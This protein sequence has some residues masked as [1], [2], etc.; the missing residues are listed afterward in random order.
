[1]PMSPENAN[2]SRKC[3]CLRFFGDIIILFR[4]HRIFGD[5]PDV[6][7]KHYHIKYDLY[8]LQTVSCCQKCIYYTRLEIIVSWAYPKH[9]KSCKTR[10]SRGQWSFKYTV[11]RIFYFAQRPVPA[12]MAMSVIAV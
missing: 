6:I 10:D 1:M 3:K 11:I 12:A 4:R 5:I 9:S 8:A 2:V 7:S